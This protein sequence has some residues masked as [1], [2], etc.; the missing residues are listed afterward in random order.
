MPYVPTA[1]TPF[2]VEAYVQMRQ[3]D[4]ARAAKT[5]GRGTLTARQLLSILRMAQALARLE[6]RLEVTQKDVEEAIRLV[7]VSKAS[8]LESKSD[9]RMESDVVSRAWALVRDRAVENKQTYSACG[10]GHAGAGG[11][12]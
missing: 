4:K 12:G 5:G 9:D 10:R 2:I 1:L 8:V 7:M 11:G 3:Q 6:L